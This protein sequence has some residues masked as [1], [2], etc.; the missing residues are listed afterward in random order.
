M[1]GS[2]LFALT[3]N[4]MRAYELP[5][6]LLMIS[7]PPQS[8]VTK[9]LRHL[10]AITYLP[11]RPCSTPMMTFRTDSSHPEELII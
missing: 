3:K 10:R 11:Y 4:N 2:E 7:N 8:E 6:G 5:K 1:N 9:V